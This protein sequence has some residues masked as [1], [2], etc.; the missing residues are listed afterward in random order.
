MKNLELLGLS[1]VAAAL[2]MTT[3]CSSSDDSS[4]PA[5]GPSA[6]SEIGAAMDMNGTSAKN[7][8]YAIK[9]G[10]AS[11]AARR[12]ARRAASA[13][14]KAAH[15]VSGINGSGSGSYTY[16]CDISGSY[17]YSYSEKNVGDTYN[18]DGTSW[19]DDY[20][21]SDNFNNCMDENSNNVNGEPTNIEVRNGTLSYTYHD[22]YN[23]DSNKSTELY[24]ETKNYT[25]SYENNETNNST[26]KVYTYNRSLIENSYWDGVWNQDRVSAEATWNDTGS[27]NGEYSKVDTNSTGS[28]ISGYKEVYG[29]LSASE[30]GVQDDSHGK[31]TANG[32]YAQ[33][34]I[35]ASGEW[36]LNEGQNYNNFSMKY[37][38]A[39]NENNISISGGYGDECLGGTVT[40]NTNPG[41]Q[42]NQDDYLDGDG[43]TGDNV[44][45]HAGA[46]TMTGTSTA[47]VAFTSDDTNH[48][49]ALL[50]VDG[51]DTN[52]TRWSELS[53]RHCVN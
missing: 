11:P 8:I 35:N 47:S 34:D 43:S 17:T 45:P 10:N 13:K 5:S 15:R 37:S 19:S 50:N 21:E 1:V 48:T 16:D 2:I 30:E 52:V 44:L 32:F 40:F 28:R 36:E 23:A 27:E 53:V 20:T 25:R 3:G 26:S 38:D 12:A 31:Y 29:N 51:A 24:S 9:D 33:Y 41:I 46:I 4:S 18:S 49:S 14:R 7:A 22:E 39:G 42:E 6:P